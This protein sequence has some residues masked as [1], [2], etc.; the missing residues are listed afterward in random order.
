[1]KRFTELRLRGAKPK[2]RVAR[3][4]VLGDG[5]GA[6]PVLERPVGCWRCW[7]WRRISAVKRSFW[8]YTHAD[9]LWLVCPVMLYWISRVWMLAYRNQM[10]DDPGG[11]LRSR[12]PRVMRWPPSSRP[13]LLRDGARLNPH[14]PLSC[15]LA[16][17]YSA[18]LRSVSGVPRRLCLPHSP[19]YPAGIR[20]TT[21]AKFLRRCAPG[22]DKAWRNG[23][24]RNPVRRE[25]GWPRCVRD[26]DAGLSDDSARSLP[27][28]PPFDRHWPC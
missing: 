12:I 28:V 21:P 10:D 13:F 4:R 19:T 9:V 1:M 22:I 23:V 18:P 3:A 11:V 8:L 27:A 26:Q 24:D 15:R 16:P 20:L 14:A 5:S 25:A 2:A 7:C 6:R 17:F